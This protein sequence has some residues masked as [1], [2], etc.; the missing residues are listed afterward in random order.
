MKVMVV[1]DDNTTRKILGLYL[2]GM[3]YETVFAENGID[4]IEKLV[5]NEVHLILTDLNMPYMDGIELTR[6][7][8]SNPDLSRIPVL[9]ITTEDDVIERE[10]AYQAGANGYLVKPVTAEGVNENIRMAL[11]KIFTHGGDPDV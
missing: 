11:K 1:D 8:K 5:S 9:M 4:A 6:T 7:L 10:K 2:K 3:G